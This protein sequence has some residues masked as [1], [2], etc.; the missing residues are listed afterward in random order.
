MK[1][2]LNRI[3]VLEAELARL[4]DWVK[5]AESRLAIVLPLSTAMLGAL[6]VLVPP[7]AM[8]TAIS[9]ISASFAA[10]LLALSIVFAALA[11]FPRTGGPKGSLLYFGGVVQKDL[12]QYRAAIQ[13]LNE[14]AY[15]GDLTDQC[16]RNAQI[17]ERKYTWIQ[18]SMAAMFLA[19][20][21]WA[22]ALL[23]LYSGRP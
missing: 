8:W 23:L 2:E 7:F 1:A 20:L 14:E 4:I 6:A 18:W 3:A 12:A 5:A 10:A 15:V 22:L 13:D 17:A 21:P 19:S 9:A 11:T 16:H